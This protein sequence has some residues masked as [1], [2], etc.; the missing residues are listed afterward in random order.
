[1]PRTRHDVQKARRVCCMAWQRADW[2]SVQATRRR[3]RALWTSPRHLNS[4]GWGRTVCAYRCVPASR[5]TASLP[6]P[7]GRS[8]TRIPCGDGYVE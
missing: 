7:L 5:Q 8:E 6:S 4:R 3:L 2:P 1:M